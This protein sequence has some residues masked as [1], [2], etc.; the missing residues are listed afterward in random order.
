MPFKIT[1]KIIGYPE[2][3]TYA[4]LPLASERPEGIYVVLTATGVW[5]VNRKRTG[6][7]RS[8]GVNWNR[9]GVSP[10]A[11]ELG[12]IEGAAPS[13]YQTVKKIFVNPATGKTVVRYDNN[14]V[15]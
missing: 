12:A 14:I 15:T 4:D 6:M 11:L 7:W 1:A 3:D 5:G 2:V 9:L 8:N 10:T 13:G